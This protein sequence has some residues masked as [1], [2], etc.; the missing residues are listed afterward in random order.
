[1]Q[2]LPFSSAHRSA[3]VA[4]VAAVAA[5]AL[6][7]CGGGDDSADTTS[8]TTTGPNAATDTTD[9]TEAA[10]D[11]TA[12]TTSPATIE[13][14]VPATTEPASTTTA[15]MSSAA[16]TTP[17]TS[18]PATSDPAST[19]PPTAAPVDL[20]QAQFCFDSEQVYVFDRV[21]SELRAPTPEQTEAAL[22]VLIFTVDAAAA[23]APPGM[24]AQPA[25]AAELLA[26]I[27]AVFDQY[28]YDT[29]AMGAAP[30]IDQ[31]NDAFEEYSTI[32]AD[33]TAFLSDV[34]ASQ[35]DV[36]D[37]QA[38]KLSPVIVELREWPLQPI[39]DQAG[40]I[41]IFVPLDWTEWIG[42]TEL[43]TATVLEA[44]PSI[45]DFES[46]WNAPG[47][48]VSVTRVD[49]GTADASGLVDEA[50][51][52]ADCTLDSTEPYEDAVYVGELHLFSGCAGIETTAVVLAVTDVDRTVEAMLEFQF[53]DGTDRE[54]L[55]RML[56]SFVAGA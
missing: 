21:T 10:G 54:L 13:T 55:D 41:R 27:E 44:S 18:D 32:L 12:P 5:L 6:S 36:L 3:A 39:A 11:T 17:D 23:S 52:T 30:E 34:C 4:A 56:A 19:A 20:E 8:V 31:L 16:T 42:S 50:L 14:T 53:P 35:L 26:E 24:E 40:D 28:E 7:A 9:P 15:P 46:T 33:L 51:A 45:E 43:G 25:R 47:V 49:A 37:S 29:E 1:M 22:A 2:R 38:A 48:L